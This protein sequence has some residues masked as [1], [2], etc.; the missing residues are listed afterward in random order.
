M[1]RP[2]LFWSFCLVVLI[3]LINSRGPT[4]AWDGP[5]DGTYFKVTGQVCDKD[6]TSFDLQILEILNDA[7]V[8][9]QDNPSE[10][11]NFIE[12]MSV[13]YDNC[14]KL[15]V[16]YDEASEI[17]LG[18]EVTL[19]G[20]FYA[21]SPAT[22]PGEFDFAHY[23]HSMGYLGRLQNVQ[24]YGVMGEAGVKE[25]LHGL[26][27]FWEDR[28]YEVFPKKE[29][30]IMA[31]ILLGEKGNVD[32]E[33]KALYQRNGI[34]HILSIS[35]LHITII[36][37]GIYK[38]LRRMGL[39]V[40]AAAICGGT[41]LV[42]YGVMTGFSVSVCRAIGMYL[43][44]MISL[45][46]GRTYDML[47]ALGF[48][49]AVMVLF[50]PAW[51]GH[52]GFLLSFGSVLGLG[53]MV[54]ALSKGK[55]EEEPGRPLKYVEGVWR[56]RLVKVWQFVCGVMSE[57]LLAG[58][59][60]TL[61]T[62]PIQLWFSYEISIYSVFLNALILPLMSAVMVTGLVAMIVPGLGIVGT[63]DVIILTGYEGLCH[64]F[65]AL[66]AA[67]WNPGRPAVWQVVVY[68]LVWAVVV[69]VMPKVRSQRK[70]HREK[71]RQWA[72]Y[73][74]RDKSGPQHR[75]VRPMQF[76]L[77]AA[78]VGILALPRFRGDRVTFLD[79]GQGDC[80][81]VQLSSGEVYLFDCGSSSRSGIGEDVLIP[82]LKY[83]GI[84]EVDAVF[85]SHGDMDHTGGL[86]E[87]LS[88]GQESH[89]KVRQLVLPNI[90]RDILVKEFEG[91]LAAADEAGVPVAVM[92]AGESWKSGEDLFLC[93]HPSVSQASLSGN[94]G[95]ECF[96]VELHEEEQ[97]LSLLLTGDVEGVGETALSSRLEQYGIQAVEVLKVAHHGSKNSTKNAFLEGVKP[98]LSVISCGRKN[99]YGHPHEETLERLEAAGSEIVT[100]PECGAI[101]I[102]LGAEI[103]VY[104]YK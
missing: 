28:L 21:F 17:I 9:Q 34:V 92:S 101:T 59:S 69:W 58:V 72:R 16:S 52:M 63:V 6:D 5:P 64:A 7:A 31:A 93:L 53:L 86:E 90:E 66:P 30:S 41:V 77:M 83:Y 37:M 74:Y 65:E 23:Y 26:R 49:G 43:L 89:I 67:M 82:F 3:A 55:D 25:W 50:R 75:L 40:W 47:T 1:R 45:L 68:Y 54:P 10:D 79:V 84:S 19:E 85:A 91:L 71:L 8:L 62:L 56:R 102:V 97:E 44:R 76:L 70:L 87:L 12:E 95:S 2:L 35:G 33:I 22:N 61:T 51:L 73:L 99:S 32:A 78:A 15:I 48:V 11:I 80:I 13:G 27:M 4:T 94:A 39:P 57:G 100:T 29:A 98:R 24:I 18:S 42:L 88:F 103:Q 60:I 36:G 20:T 14:D 38:L 104:G 96:Y 46:I 81:C